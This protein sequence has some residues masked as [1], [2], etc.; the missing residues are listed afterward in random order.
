MLLGLRLHRRQKNGLQRDVNFSTGS[1]FR[2]PSTAI[3]G[4]TFL[5][6][7]PL[8]VHMICGQ[9]LE[10]SLARPDQKCSNGV[11]VSRKQPS[12][13]RLVLILPRTQ[14]IP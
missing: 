14:K 6:W 13:S 8:Q 10:K 4:P 11:L 3:S 9:R 2:M 5:F 7:H 12:H 1:N